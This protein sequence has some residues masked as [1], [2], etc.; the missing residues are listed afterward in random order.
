M[1]VIILITIFDLQLAL[2]NYLFKTINHSTAHLIAIFVSHIPVMI[3]E[4]YLVGNRLTEAGNE[5]AAKKT[6]LRRP[7]LLTMILQMLQMSSLPPRLDISSASHF[8]KKRAHIRES[9]ISHPAQE[10]KSKTRKHLCETPT[11]YQIKSNTG[12]IST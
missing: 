11:V 1:L 2:S 10:R 5:I 9:I 8:P 3:N 6:T 4:K 12:R 7:V